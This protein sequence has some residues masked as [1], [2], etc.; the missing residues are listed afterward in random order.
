MHSLERKSLFD[1]VTCIHHGTTLQN[2]KDRLIQNAERY[3]H[4]IEELSA[5]WQD[6][7]DLVEKTVEISQLLTF[8][9]NELKYK[10]P[11]A[12]IPLEKTPAEHLKYL[13]LNGAKT[14]YPKGVPE[15]VLK[16]IDYE[17]SIICDLQYEDYFLTLKDICN[18]ADQK[19]ILYQGRG[20]AANSVVCFCLGLTSID[21]VQL[22]LLFERFISRE[23][24]E[25]PDIDID[26][27]HERREEVIQYIYESYGQE[28]AAMVCTVIRYRSKMALRETAKV[29]NIPLQTINKIIKHMGRDGLSRLY[30]PDAAKNLIS[31]K[32]LGI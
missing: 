32:T 30:E 5:L 2:S 4:T 27:E 23:R 26:F 24:R 3:L 1:V 20:S 31:T 12:K 7:I 10:Y 17:I 29:F 15:N 11:A 22:D 25:P 28:K 6:R 18:F 9:L 16:Q 14:R 8:H 13:V 19:N 21:P